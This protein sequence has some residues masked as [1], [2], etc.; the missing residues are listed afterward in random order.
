MQG[1]VEAARGR[2]PAARAWP[3][4]PPSCC[5][6]QRLALHWACSGVLVGT[7]DLTGRP[8]G[9]NTW[10]SCRASALPAPAP[11]LGGSQKT[12]LVQCHLTLC[13]CRLPLCF[14]VIRE[15]ESTIISMENVIGQWS[16]WAE[17]SAS[18][19]TVV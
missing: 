16:L 12:H 2:I 7:G 19:V 8:R 4:D 10:E 9:G 13:T 11:L 3:A 6:Q 14:W 15:L 17:T 1:R 5:S 18:R